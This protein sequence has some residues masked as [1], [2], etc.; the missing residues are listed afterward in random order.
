MPLSYLEVLDACGGNRDELGVRDR[1]AL[2]Q[3]WRE[4]Y[5]ARLHAATGKWQW[6][7]FDW[8]VFSWEHAP[9]YSGRK[10]VACYRE[11]AASPFLVLPHEARGS[12]ALPAFRLSEARLPLFEGLWL[13]VMV[14]PEDL[15]WTTAFT[16]E[17]DCGPYF[18]RREWLGS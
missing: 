4:V 6:G 13:D 11:Q 18:S 12:E 1:W 2:A 5:A 16:H 10:A 3:R 17:E 15:S 14:W 8:H 7:G 9:A